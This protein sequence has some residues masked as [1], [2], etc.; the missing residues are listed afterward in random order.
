MQTPDL[1]RSE[2]DDFFRI[3]KSL[4]NILA[5]GFRTDLAYN[6]PAAYGEPAPSLIETN[7]SASTFDDVL[8][9]SSPPV[10]VLPATEISDA[11]PK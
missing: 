5:K 8:N 9:F 11:T 6:E 2:A 3:L 10:D 4:N 7:G 1:Q